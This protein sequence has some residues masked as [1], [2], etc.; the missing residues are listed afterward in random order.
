MFASRGGAVTALALVAAY[1]HDVTT[2]VAHELRPSCGRGAFSHEETPDEPG[3]FVEGGATV[4]LVTPPGWWCPAR[5]R[6]PV[7]SPV[8]GRVLWAGRGWGRAGRR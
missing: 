6:W 3:S 5:A 1:P 8:S 4:F 2:L 7:W